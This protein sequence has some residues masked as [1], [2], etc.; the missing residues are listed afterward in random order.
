MMGTQVYKRLNQGTLQNILLLH[1]QIAIDMEHESSFL[2]VIPRID[3]DNIN[4]IP[5]F[6]GLV[7]S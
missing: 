7:H 6:G 1:P 3:S 5:N 4:L 2:S